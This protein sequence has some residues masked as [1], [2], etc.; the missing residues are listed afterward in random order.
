MSLSLFHIF[1]HLIFTK[2]HKVG[3]LT[4]LTEAMPAEIDHLV[5]MLQRRVKVNGFASCPLPSL[6]TLNASDSMNM[7]LKGIV[8]ASRLAHA[9]R[10]REQFFVLL[11]ERS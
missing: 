1:P 6:A 9:V 10:N 7:S 11:I 4:I 8:Q 5:R 3:T 2:R